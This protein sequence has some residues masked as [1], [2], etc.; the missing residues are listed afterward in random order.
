MRVTS[1]RHRRARAMAILSKVLA[2]DSLQSAA[3]ALE[4]RLVPLTDHTWHVP[5]T[6]VRL[7]VLPCNARYYRVW[8]A[9]R[10]SGRVTLGSYSRA[11]AAVLR[12]ARAVKG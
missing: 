6:A 10:E 5:G 8:V 2:M 9:C 11:G 1:P 7:T 3:Q 4:I 12:V